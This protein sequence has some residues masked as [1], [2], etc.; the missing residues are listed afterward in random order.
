L[1]TPLPDPAEA[2]FARIAAI[3]PDIAV[4]SAVYNGDGMI[5]DVVIVNDQLV[6]RFPKNE[7]GRKALAG[8]L[9]VLRAVRP[10]VGVDIPDPFYVSSDA[11]AYR[12][13]PGETLSRELLL[14]LAP[15]AQQRLADDLG[16]F[17]R[18]LHQTPVN[19]GLPR[20]QAPSRRSDW[21][22]MWRKID[23]SVLAISMD[24]QRVWATELFDGMLGDEYGFD[25][26][27]RLI[28]GDL[29]PYHLLCDAAAGRLTGVIDFGTAGLGDPATDL[30][31][32]VQIYGEPF[33][34]RMLAVYP[35][36]EALLPRARFYAE[37]IELQ[38]VMLGLTRSE[39][40]WFTAHLGGAR[41]LWT[42]NPE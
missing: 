35:E 8:E 21:A 37:A 14:R 40:F 5:N 27:P 36:A 28:H 9:A 3:A 6:F 29:G 17:L 1:G 41:D 16:R 39:P 38:W 30:G 31:G 34:R 20:T 7:Y 19:D 18:G 23:E 42:D 33:V 25:Y 12:L 15:E 11:I 13:L 2:F 32:L 22:E 26:E 10:R 4:R 24:H